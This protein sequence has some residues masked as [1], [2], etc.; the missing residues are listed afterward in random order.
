MA[1][2]AGA[3]A[4]ARATFENLRLYLAELLEPSIVVVPVLVLVCGYTLWRALRRD[5]PWR[6][7]TLALVFQI[8]VCLLVVVEG[9]NSRQFLVTQTLVFCALAA[10]VVDAGEAALRGRGSSARLFGA[11]VV[12]PLA[13]LLLVSSVQRVQALLPDGS[14]SLF[15]RHR[16]APQASAMSDWMAENVQEGEHVLVTPAYSLNRYLV[17]LDGGRHEWVFLRLDQEPCE[18]RP[19]I[20]TRCD[21][22]DNAISRTPPDAVW[23]HMVD[24]CKAI[25]LSMTN[26]L[27]Q[28]RRTGSGYVMI[29]GGY[30]LP[31]ILELPPRLQE[32][33][34]FE[35][36]HSELDP[37]ASGENHGL[38]L[39]KSTG[40]APAAVPTQMNANT[41]LRLKHCEQA[42]D[43]GYEKRMR[44]MFPN[45]ISTDQTGATARR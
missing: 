20:Q 18:P 21:P 7:L 9:W 14:G 15:D 12:V 41:A 16:A 8:P 29:S 31:G 4:L 3:P 33:G 25:S 23:V 27:E 11:L 22:D 26:L 30:S 1:L 37:G 17:F 28:A 38:V 39:L 34:A 44:S 40:R 13:T 6:L 19:N 35:V 24:E 2:A 45:G 36:V 10:L 32:S 5:G 43:P 42:K